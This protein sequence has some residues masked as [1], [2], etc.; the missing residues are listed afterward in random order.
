M[1][2][3]SNDEMIDGNLLMLAAAYSSL[4]VNLHVVQISGATLTHFYLTWNLISII[5]KSQCHQKEMQSLI[6]TRDEEQL[7]LKNSVWRTISLFNNG[8]R[9]IY[10]LVGNARSFTNTTK[11]KRLTYSKLTIVSFLTLEMPTVTWKHLQSNTTVVTSM[12]IYEVNQLGF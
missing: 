7:N 12:C 1:F 10:K 8:P 2:R 11:H 3:M 6:Y 4:H 9:M 5:A